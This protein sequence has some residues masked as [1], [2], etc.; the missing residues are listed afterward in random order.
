MSQTTSSLC[1][2][3]VHCL[4]CKKARSLR[5]H[6]CRFLRTVHAETGFI[7][8]C[9]ITE[10]IIRGYDWLQDFV[11]V[12]YKFSLSFPVCFVCKTCF[13]SRNKTTGTPT[14]HCAQSE[15][16]R[17]PKAKIIR[18]HTQFGLEEACSWVSTSSSSTSSMKSR[19]DVPRRSGRKLGYAISNQVH[20]G[21]L[22]RDR[23]TTHLYSTFTLMQMYSRIS[24]IGSRKLQQKCLCCSWNKSVCVQHQKTFVRICR[25]LTTDGKTW[26]EMKAVETA[27]QD[28]VIGWFAENTLIRR[29]WRKQNSTDVS[30]LLIWLHSVCI[31][32]KQIKKNGNVRNL[33]KRIFLQLSLRRFKKRNK[34][35]IAVQ[36]WSS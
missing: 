33:T 31:V 20:C 4:W 19:S 2:S 26:W 34:L 10:N 12:W 13:S 16:N 23:R 29:L 22:I 11:G 3:C 1:F 15:T 24:L 5:A 7:V 8:C 21:F 9:R 18:H 6:V 17:S 27:W 28:F 36:R 32:S 30:Q 14:H 25:K 35:E